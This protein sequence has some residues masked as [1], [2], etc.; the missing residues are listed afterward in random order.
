MET[1]PRLAAEP[2]THHQGHVI[3]AEY[4]SASQ[5]DEIVVRLTL[6]SSPAETAAL[7]LSLSRFTIVNYC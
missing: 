5:L 2:T 7:G 1:T 3:D 4:C 6:L